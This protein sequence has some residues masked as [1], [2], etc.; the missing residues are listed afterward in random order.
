MSKEGI[1]PIIHSILIQGDDHQNQI[2]RYEKEF[3]DRMIELAISMGEDEN[4]IDWQ[5]LAGKLAKKREPRLKDKTTKGRPKTW[6]LFEIFLLVE[7]VQRLSDK[8]LSEYASLQ[9]ISK[10]E[11]WRAFLNLNKPP[12]DGDFFEALRKHYKPDSEES[13]KGKEMVQGLKHLPQE[14]FDTLVQRF[15]HRN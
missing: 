7:N 15:L 8:G 11:H 5:R 3:N 6:G 14:E 12:T 10:L 9:K 2:Q 13:L 1:D 4:D